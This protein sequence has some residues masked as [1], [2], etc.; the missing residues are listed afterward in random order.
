MYYYVAADSAA[1]Y[2]NPNNAKPVRTIR[3][4]D[5]VM[6]M[7]SVAPDWLVLKRDG[8]TYYSKSGEFTTTRPQSGGST[9]PSSNPQ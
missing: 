7:G 1:L 4:G 5:Q 8:A 3:R 9:A 6:V 2:A